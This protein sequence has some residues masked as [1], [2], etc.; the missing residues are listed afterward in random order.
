MPEQEQPL[1]RKGRAEKAA[2]HAGP[3]VVAQVVG[4]K[5]DAQAT[6]GTPLNGGIVS[7]QPS[8]KE[9][10]ATNARGI[11]GPDGTFRL[12]TFKEGDGALP[13]K[14]RAIVLSPPPNNKPNEP[15]PK[16]NVHKKFGSYDTSGLVVDSTPGPNKITLKVDRPN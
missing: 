3:R 15:T 11:V 7:L 16:P 1:I 13:G 2:D 14:H 6:D 10:P 4:P 8:G 9:G 5:G 12:T